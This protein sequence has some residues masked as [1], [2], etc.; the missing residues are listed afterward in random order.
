[1]N[2][3]PT[4]TRLIMLKAVCTVMVIILGGSLFAA[5]AIGSD[6]CGMKCCCQTG[7]THMQSSA[8]KQMRSTTGCCTGVPLNPCDL[9]STKPFELPEIVLT[10]CC[11]EFSNAGGT[12]PALTD[13]NGRRQSTG[14]DFF[15][16]VLD[17]NFN[18]PPLY[19]QN[20]TFLI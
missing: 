13:A 18:S 12:A 1:M 2:K 15:S 4:G 6:G 14:A 5:G 20:L 19:L 11:D 16:Q 17:P 3:I 7:S 9:Q 10:V 8:D